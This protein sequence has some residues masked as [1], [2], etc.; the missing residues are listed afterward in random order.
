QKGMW[1]AV[2]S[3]YETRYVDVKIDGEI[4]G[5][6]TVA[7]EEGFQQWRLISLAVGLLLLLVAPIVSSWV[8][9]YYSSSMAIG[10]FLVIIIVLFQGMKLLPTG[11]KNIFYLTIYGSVLGAGSFLL[12]QFSMIVNSIL[13]SFGMSEEMHNPVSIPV[14]LS[15]R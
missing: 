5:S 9:F 8:P 12:H 10:I 4:S 7:L 1:D 2:M 6:V 15:F 14:Y 3:P 11:R 13:Q